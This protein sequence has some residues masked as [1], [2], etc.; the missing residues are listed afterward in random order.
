[1]PKKQKKLRSELE[2]HSR[3]L[4]YLTQILNA[5]KIQL[6]D[7]EAQIRSLTL[8]LDALQRQMQDKSSPIVDQYHRPR[9]AWEPPPPPPKTRPRWQRKPPEGNET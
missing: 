5:H 6:L 2:S 3:S 8:R 1:M 4:K 9:A 7:N